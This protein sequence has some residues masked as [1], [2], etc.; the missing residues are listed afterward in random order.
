[1][2]L[3]KIIFCSYDNKIKEESSQNILGSVLNFKENEYS[4]SC[5]KCK[6]TLSKLAQERDVSISEVFFLSV[7]NH[8]GE[9]KFIC[10]TCFRGW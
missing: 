2:E 6:T 4:K 7:I 1:M 9:R 10:D 5:F 3:S 8:N